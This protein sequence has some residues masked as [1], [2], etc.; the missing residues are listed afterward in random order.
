[1]FYSL[2]ITYDLNKLS[3]FKPSY[4]NS[5]TRQNSNYFAYSANDLHFYTLIVPYERD[6]QARLFLACYCYGFSAHLNYST[7]FTSF[8]SITF[9]HNHYLHLIFSLYEMVRPITTT[10]YI[11][12][13]SSF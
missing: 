4:Y 6:L 7:Y 5:S 13:S 3:P 11:Y 9:L 2:L 8:N 10:F 12:F 1:M